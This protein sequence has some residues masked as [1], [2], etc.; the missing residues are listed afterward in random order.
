MRATTLTSLAVAGWLFADVLLAFS[1][2]V[3]GSEPAPPAAR[4]SPSPSPSPTPSPTRLGLEHQPVTL[5]L[6]IS[7]EG[8]AKQRDTAVGTLRQA[9]HRVPKLY[10]RRAGMVL[11]FAANNNTAADGEQL[12]RSVN[13]LLPQADP[14][15]F[16]S[17]TTRYFHSLSN[18]SGWVEL[19]IY[20][21][22]AS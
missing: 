20:L 16:H 18:P 6:R 4:P 9:L 13:A 3:L 17:T 19:D 12:A 8:A 7:P 21:F 10:G 22:T 1:I 11:T 14:T 2:V 15:L 5:E